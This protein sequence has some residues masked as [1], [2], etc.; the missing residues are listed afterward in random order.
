[1]IA[2]LEEM[3]AKLFGVRDEIAIPV[4]SDDDLPPRDRQL[5]GRK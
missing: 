5:K 1:M 3:F 2:Y 4:R